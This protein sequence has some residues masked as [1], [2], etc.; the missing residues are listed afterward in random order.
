M[1]KLFLFLGAVLIL[2]SGSYA[3][4]LKGGEITYVADSLNPLKYLF[5]L[6][7]YTDNVGGANANAAQVDV[8]FY[9]GDGTSEKALRSNGKDGTPIGNETSINYYY[10]WHSFPGA[11]SYPVSVGI[12]NRNAGTINLGPSPDQ[13]S[14]FVQTTLLI[15]AAIKGNNSVQFGD[16]PIFLVPV[17][18]IYRQ[19]VLATDPDGDSLSFQMVKSQQQITDGAGSNIPGY[20]F[21]DSLSI[22]PVSG[23]IRWKTPQMIG[24]YA[25]AVKISEWRNG[26]LI[27]TVI[28]DYQVFVIDD[29]DPGQELHL[30][31][32]QGQE[33][34]SSSAV[35]VETGAKAELK[36]IL[37]D[38]AADSIRWSAFSEVLESSK[39]ATFTVTDSLNFKVGKFSWVTIADNKR[40]QPYIVTFRGNSVFNQKSTLQSDLTVLLYVGVEVPVIPPP[41]SITTAIDGERA[42]LSRIRVCPNP[43]N[44]Q[45]HVSIQ[46]NP[47]HLT[48]LLL[49]PSGREVKWMEN[50]SQTEF[51]ISIAHFTSGLYVYRLVS[52]SKVLGSGKLVKL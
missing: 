45:F 1:K 25:F 46:T 20:Q 50:L 36:V 35:K 27:G 47:V 14:F 5:T 31:K 24:Q 18:K 38:N 15:N 49:D 42:P 4:H 12:Q 21:P 3:T 52:G 43:V 11:G 40:N 9:F 2:T 6:T 19:N 39:P 44:D 13:K 32:P 16:K 37:S 48:F 33:M 22:H 10:I 17:G 23:E 29:S 41:S 26:I 7:T 34:V 30:Y 28:R 8:T 51:D